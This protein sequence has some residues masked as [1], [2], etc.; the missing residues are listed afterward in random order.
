[1]RGIVISVPIA[2]IYTG[3]SQYLMTHSSTAKRL[4]E[5]P[6]ANTA[7][8]NIGSSFGSFQLLITIGAVATISA[9][10]PPK[11]PK[12]DDCVV[13]HTTTV[14]PQTS[15]QVLS[16]FYQVYVPQ[17]NDKTTIIAGL[18]T[19]IKIGNNVVFHPT[20]D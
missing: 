13:C 14:T 1:M 9:S 2:V 19:P 8:G 7:H 3:K 16:I 4:T 6:N 15:T 20:P 12:S 11:I 5:L 18:I 10:I 17:R